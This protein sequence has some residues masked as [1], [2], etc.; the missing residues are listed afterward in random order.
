MRL[1][2]SQM[3]NASVSGH[4]KGYAALVKTQEQI[5]SGHR[6]QT[7]ADDPVGSARLLQL[8]QQAGQLSQ[9]KS[10]LTDA[11][12]SLAQ[13]ESILQSMIKI[14]D[15]ARSLAGQA[16]NGAYNDHDRRA[17]AAELQQ[18]ENELFGLMNSKNASGEYWFSG[19]QSGIPPYVRNP[20]GTYRY[21]GDQSQ[22]YLQVATGVQLSINDSGFETF[23]S[24]KN[25]SR[26]ETA[27][28]APATVDGVQRLYMSGGAIVDQQ[29][30]D[31]DF[32][33]NG[34][35]TLTIKAQD[36]TNPYSPLNYEIEDGAGNVTAGPYDPAQENPKITF[37]GVEFA[38]D[39]LLGA[40]ETTYGALL[41]GHQFSLGMAPDDFTVI[42]SSAAQISKVVVGN[43]PAEA[44]AYANA[45]PAGGL[46]LKYDG[47]TSTF[48][49]MAPDG[50][51]PLPWPVTY[52]ADPLPATTGTISIPAVGLTLKTA[53]AFGGGDQ[54]KVHADSQET[55]NILNTIVALRQSLQEPADGIKG[56]GMRI[57][58]AVAV[59]LGNLDSSMIQI[60]S[61]QAH[62][63]AR[64]NVIDTLTAENESLGIFNAQTQSAIRDTDQFEAA[65]RLMLQQTK[66]E[67]AH[68]AFVRVSQLSL[69]DR[70]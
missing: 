16:G 9:Y 17:I 64:M 45:F 68:A 67:A 56:G 37:G 27:E 58:E 47:A 42:A 66:L 2:T 13:E 6:I 21:Q 39:P 3:F 70:L 28:M 7:A 8:E 53:G 34:P 5:T 50:I 31:K 36:P 52:V 41:D 43:T 26:T 49:A 15:R 25:V 57:R 51:T 63:G 4:Q 24:A 30:F 54:F 11:T 33:A 69:F 40:G 65:S 38:L 18:I 62:I 14:G 46:T 32:R 23:E 61:T 20:D 44:A 22:Q 19:S 35:Y 10:N 29:A 59:A 60:E 48:S 55:R 1:S 12:N